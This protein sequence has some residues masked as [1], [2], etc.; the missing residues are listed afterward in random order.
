MLPHICERCGQAHGCPPPEPY[1]W[2]IPPGDPEEVIRAAAAE[3][4]ALVSERDEAVGANILNRNAVARLS[5]DL[6]R[7]KAALVRVRDVLRLGAKVGPADPL[8]DPY[9]MVLGDRVGFGAMMSSAS[10]IWRERLV[11]KGYPAGG[12]FVGSPCRSDVEAALKTIEAALA[13][14]GGPRSEAAKDLDRDIDKGLRP[15]DPVEG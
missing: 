7:A 8:T 5:A 3:R 9:V 1:D 14:K 2:P 11:S 4:K 12:E 13:A 6:A 10:R 15:C